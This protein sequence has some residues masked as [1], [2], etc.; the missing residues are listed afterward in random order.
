[1]ENKKNENF[2]FVFFLRNLKN[3][4]DVKIRRILDRFKSPEELEAVSDYELIRLEGINNN[5]IES[6]HAAFKRRREILAAADAML[7]LCG[8]KGINFVTYLDTDYPGNLRN[9][10][11]PPSLLYYKGSITD[12]CNSSISIVGTR[13]PSDYGRKACRELAE[14]L[15]ELK[16]PIVSGLA[17]GI[18]SISH[19][20]A[21]E[22][23]NTTYAILGGGIDRIYP[24]GNKIL[25][26]RI[27][28]C[29]ALVSEFDTG[30][31]AERV[32]F[33]R[34]NRI[35]SGISLG[36]IVIESGIRGG[37]LITA[38]FAIDQNREVFAVPGNIDSKKSE[39]CNNLIK[40]GTAKLVS[41]SDDIISEL[42]FKLQ[43]IIGKGIKAKTKKEIPEMSIFETKIYGILDESEPIH[44]DRI[45]EMSGL[46]ISDCLV[47]LLMMEFKG[48][49]IQTPGKYFL[50]RCHT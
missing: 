9:I 18:D 36:T 39:G 44:I 31:Q 48:H 42:S 15:S 19:K 33:P 20:A 45:S 28:E 47:N 23:G 40:K 10:Y 26:E 37:S 46:N 6:I 38:E 41:S 16:I 30:S 4:G 50:K 29:G 5:T 7:D 43:D 27:T 13:Y 34:R 49:V 12:R 21:L 32:N 22:S 17:T 2:R 1:M 24:P 14:Q 8:E 11:D 3:T 35:I 25:S